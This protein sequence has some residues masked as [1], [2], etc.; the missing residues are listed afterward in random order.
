VTKPLTALGVLLL[1]VIALGSYMQSIGVEISRA[2]PP[3]QIDLELASSPN[4][5]V[6]LKDAWKPDGIAAVRTQINWDFL[7]IALYV[8]ALVIAVRLA[9]PAY[10]RRFPPVFRRP[11]WIIGAAVGAGV[12]DL[13]ENAAMYVVLD[14]SEASAWQYV[15]HGAAVAKFVLVALVVLYVLVSL[16]LRFFDWIGKEPAGV[17][18]ESVLETELEVVRLARSRRKVNAPFDKAQL[19][20]LALSGGGIRSATFNLGVLQGLAELG[21]LKTIDYLSTVSGGGYIGTWFTAWVKRK[22]LDEVERDLQTDRL[23]PADDSTEECVSRTAHD[24]RKSRNEAREIRA[25]REY[26]NYLTPRRGAASGDTWAFIG[27]YVRNLLLNQLILGLVLMAVLLLPRLFALYTSH[28]A[29]LTFPE[30][31]HTW[32]LVAGTTLLALAVTVTLMS[33]SSQAREPGSAR[34]R[35]WLA[36]PLVIDFLVVLPSLVATWLLWLWWWSFCQR[37]GVLVLQSAVVGGLAFGA[38]WAVGGWMAELFRPE[39]P[40]GFS[41]AAVLSALQ[42][43][44]K[45]APVPVFSLIAGSAIAGFVGV[46]L[47]WGAYHLLQ[48]PPVA[49]LGVPEWRLVGWGFPL[50]VGVM[51]AVQILHVG[52]MGWG[53]TEDAREWW[54]RMG[55]LL[56]LWTIAIVLLSLIALEGPWLLQKLRIHH[57]VLLSAAWGAVST[58]GLTLARRAA[59]ASASPS[60]TVPILIAVAQPVFVVGLLLTLSW[61]LHLLLPVLVEPV[62][63]A[64]G[65]VPT[66]MGV[67]QFLGPWSR[68]HGGVGLGYWEQMEPTLGGCLW[69]YLV[70]CLATAGLLSW[71]IGINRFSMHSLYRN[72]LVRCYLGASREP[73]DRH[74]QPF[75]GIDPED[76]SLAF[77]DLASANE[78]QSDGPFPI[79]NTTLNLVNTHNLAW[80]QRKG[81]SFVLTPL[82][83]GYEFVRQNDERVSAYQETRLFGRRLRLGLAM[84][85]SGAAASPNMGEQTSGSRSFL[86]TV[87]N[88]RLGWWL[89][90]PRWTLGNRWELGPPLGLLYLFWELLGRTNEENSYVYLS[91]GGHFENLGLYELVRRRCRHIVVSDAGEDHALQFAD[92]GNAIEKCRTDF[93]VDIDLDIEQLRRD[94]TSHMSRWHCAVGT[95]H[96]ERA[97]AGMPSGVIIYLKSSLTGDEP[98]D[99]QRYAAAHAAFPHEST[100]EQWF[101]ESQFESYRALGHHVALQSIGVLGDRRVWADA[102]PEDLFVQMREHWY[103]PS[104]F[105][106]ESFTKHTATYTALLGTLRTD[107]FLR[108]LDAQVFPE[109]TDLMEAATGRVVEPVPWSLALGLP[110]SKD[111]RRAGFYFC[112]EVIQLMEDAYVD[113]NLEADHDH[114]DNRGWMNLFRHWSWSGMFR[115]TW[116]ISASIYGARFQRFCERFLDLRPG[117]VQ[118][119]QRLTWM[120]WMAAATPLQWQE[121]K[122]THGIDFWEAQ[123]MC[124]FFAANPAAEDALSRGSVDIA[125]FHVVLGANLG[126]TPALTFNVGFALVATGGNGRARLIFFRIQD[127]MRKM[128]LARGALRALLAEYD[129]GLR[130]DVQPA[131]MPGDLTTPAGAPPN[132]AFP[133]EA[134]VLKFRNLFESVRSEARHTPR[135]RP[136]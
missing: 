7:L 64:L 36:A 120:P 25:L 10:T 8:A 54:G 80:Q 70:A 122:R 133:S 77:E 99:V 109:W 111:E 115:A 126:S 74:P 100:A 94:E 125:P 6:A 39:G 112:N 40:I 124:A 131:I 17:T 29:I 87:F 103:P 128:G 48:V 1:A 76:D 50:A 42:A 33:L 47:A 127:H 92:L 85:I 20:G 38:I 30:Q 44:A 82:H 73:Q 84:A 23:P 60:R 43:T 68:N 15:V 116:A 95:I 79:Y 63:A 34:P 129:G 12:L 104:R 108:F 71:R 118:I 18:F 134:T 49:G 5:A 13:I 14:T 62:H 113:L 41:R 96:Y 86:M 69:V 65:L 27:S 11:R 119:R 2:S 106:A 89:A 35:G 37:G 21:L 58:L 98:T 45:T 102:R 57:R 81:A 4:A 117:D 135:R 3:R 56:A 78:A 105:V 114:P 110:D 9:A 123:L 132:E 67:V 130:N 52:L 59:R 24:D 90:N 97:H 83:S 28:W 32:M 66:M 53:F 61:M 121:I 31:P 46:L 75:T 93:G 88:I 55:G 51:L 101:T 22:S 72:R 26:S 107:P 136:K 19:V 91:D 16:T